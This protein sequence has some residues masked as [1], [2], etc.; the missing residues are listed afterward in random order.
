MNQN[1]V[2]FHG[3]SGFMLVWC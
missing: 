2:N 3:E 1:N